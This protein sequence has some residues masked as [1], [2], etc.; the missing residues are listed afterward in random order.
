[1]YSIWAGF[2]MKAPDDLGI[3]KQTVRNLHFHVPM[4]FTMIL[5]LF[6]AFILSISQLAKPNFRTD[7]M[8]ASFTTTAIFF[9]LLGISTGSFWARFTWSAWW[10]PDPKLNGAAIG[11]LIYLAYYAL[12]KSIDEPKKR[13]RLSAVYNLLAF[14]LFIV[15]I[16]VLPK[17]AGNSLH[18][19]SGDSV[20]F[21]QYDL[22]NDL[23][24]VFYPAVLGWLLIGTW[25][26]T[27]NARINS[28]RLKKQYDA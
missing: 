15:L 23:R 18:P 25:L 4:W 19:G 21:N 1:M 22:D 7:S 11:L 10:T 16:I 5:L 20:G 14:P 3:L 9:G 26:A 13:G 24:K 12:R 8:A 17:I 27:L 28:L 2:L 6:T